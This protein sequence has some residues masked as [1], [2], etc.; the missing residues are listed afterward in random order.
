MK[1]VGRIALGV[2][3]FSL[4]QNSF[5]YH[6]WVVGAVSTL[7]KQAD[8][9]EKTVGADSTANIPNV[10]NGIAVTTGGTL[11]KF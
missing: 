4:A 2:F 6:L 1:L 5:G 7:N 9:E 3:M 11:R 8:G 10:G